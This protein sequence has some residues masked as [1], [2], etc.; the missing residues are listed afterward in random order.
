MKALFLCRPSSRAG[1]TTYRVVFSEIDNF[2]DLLAVLVPGRVEHAGITGEVVGDLCLEIALD[3][4]GLGRIVCGHTLEQL[5]IDE[6]CVPQKALLLKRFCGRL[7]AA[8]QKL[9]RPES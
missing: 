7:K 9:Y 2:G 3:V 8:D 5:D 4:H 1:A 6:Q